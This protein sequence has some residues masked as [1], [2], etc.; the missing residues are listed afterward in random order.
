[1]DREEVIVIVEEHTSKCQAEMNHKIELIVLGREQDTTMRQAMNDKLDTI[2]KQSKSNFEAFKQHA[3]DELAKHDAADRKHDEAIKSINKL[4]TTVSDLILETKKNSGFVQSETYNR[5]IED[6]ARLLVESE[7]KKEKERQDAI[8]ANAIPWKK[9][10]E[11]VILT[12]L[13]IATGGVITIVVL[14][15][16]AYFFLGMDTQ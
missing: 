2:S 8:D 4:A 12:G 7:K 6:A 5:K 1:M 14:G 10:K 15:F 3:I 16:K 13:T 11:R 9:Y